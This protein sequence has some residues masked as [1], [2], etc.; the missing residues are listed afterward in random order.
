MAVGA[1]WVAQL[2]LFA[3]GWLGP[4]RDPSA[5]HTNGRLPRPVRMLLSGS[6]V[7][8]A[9]LLWSMQSGTGSPYARFVFFG[10]LASC[11]GDLIMARLIPVPNRLIGGMTAFGAAHVLYVTAYM[12]TLWFN[13]AA[14]ANPGLWAGLVL[15]GLATLLGWSVL[16]RNPDKP[17]PLNAGALGYGLLV[18]GMAAVALALASALGGGWWL[19]ALGGLV[20]V[21]SDL[22]IGMTDIGGARLQ[23]A[24]DWIWLTYV[25]GQMGIIYAGWV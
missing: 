14:V 9:Y 8:A 16:I 1:L 25:A 22:L 2:V 10:M 12:R 13:G 17:K 7:L 23:N 24:N 11:V 21:I 20:F 6:L 5:L 3:V 4:W 18:G 19:A 15:Y